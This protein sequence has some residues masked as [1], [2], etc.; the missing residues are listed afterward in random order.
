MKLAR[1]LQSFL[2]VLPAHIGIIDG[3]GTILVMVNEAWRN[4]AGSN[5]ATEQSTAKGVNYLAVCDAAEGDRSE[6]AAAFAA[7][8]RSVLSGRRQ[9]YAMEYPCHSPTEK[10][11]FVG[12]VTSFPAGGSRR[13]VVAHENISER[14]ELEEILGAGR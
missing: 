9:E 10:R 6:E 12:R 14:K 13:A 11:W 3:S 4:F 5:G 1:D 7:G 2:A 8:I